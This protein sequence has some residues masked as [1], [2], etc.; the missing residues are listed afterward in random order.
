MSERHIIQEEGSLGDIVAS[1]KALITAGR[2]DEIVE[3]RGG[4]GHVPPGPITHIYPLFLQFAHESLGKSI[5]EVA[6]KLEKAKW[7]LSDENRALAAE[8]GDPITPAAEA[9]IQAWLFKAGGNA[10]SLRRELLPSGE[11]PEEVKLLN[12]QIEEMTSMSQEALDVPVGGA[13]KVRVLDEKRLARD[14][15]E[16]R[17]PPLRDEIARMLT[18]D[19][20]PARA[21]DPFAQEMARENERVK[22]LLLEATGKPLVKAI[23]EIMQQSFPDLLQAFYPRIYEHTGRYH[24]PRAMAAMMA[25]VVAETLRYGHE[26]SATAYR[27][28]MPGLAYLRER[29]MPHFFVAPDLLEAVQRTDFDNDIDWTE[30]ALPYECGILMLPK[31][32]LVHPTDGEVAMLMWARLK[33]GEQPSPWPGVPIT[34]IPHDSFVLLGACP[35]TMI[36]YDSILTSNVRPTM[37][38]HNLFYRGEG[39]PIP[40]IRRMTE[41]DSDLDERDS[42]FL[43][44]MGVILFGTFLAM[45][46][47][48]QLVERGALL[49]RVGKAGNAREFWSP[50]VIGAK[51]KFKRETA[52]VVEG[53][54]VVQQRE[55][56]THASP[57]L[58]WRRG[59]YRNQPV[60]PGRKERKTIWLE[61]CLI[62]AE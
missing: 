18:R 59:H 7:A 34:V 40:H 20:G 15:N 54:F 24:S 61:P 25:N 31:G 47:R 17:L 27:L 5:A 6:E 48:P 33:A 44:Q 30:L 23:E 46:A 58:H 45:N 16:I 52:R 41:L 50:N 8:N 2:G 29:R 51:Y 60:G 55:H 26:R 21:D 56:G 11:F 12:A 3:F 32:A 62:G 4:G 1:L 22:D 39:D 53:R 28:M 19:P 49:K 37:R 42:A 57:R 36:W 43:E 10:L 35:E 9:E 38:L 13:G 14:E